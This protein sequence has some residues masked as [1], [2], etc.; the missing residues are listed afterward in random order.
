MIKTTT[1]HLPSCPEA[2]QSAVRDK[3][4]EPDS[5]L[6]SVTLTES[7]PFKDKHIISRQYRAIVNRMN[8]V[9]VLHCYEDGPL[10]NEVA[11]NELIWGDILEI[12]RTAPNG[13]TMA[14]LRDAIPE[15]EKKRFSL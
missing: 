3:L 5:E 8:L 7:T 2:L 9:S 14:E 4:S 15:Q 10:K 6:L 13:S 11:T 1:V 12:I